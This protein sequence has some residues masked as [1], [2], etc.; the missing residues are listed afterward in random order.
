Y[1]HAIEK[2]RQILERNPNFADALEQIARAYEATGRY[3]EA[4]KL[5]KQVIAKNPAMAEVTALSLG[6]IYLELGNYA[7]ARAHAEL[8][9]KR[10]PGAAHLLLGRIALAQHDYR[11]AEKE[12]RATMSDSHFSMQAAMLASE[13]L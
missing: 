11:T 9:L 5:C 13:S 6:A 1:P 3:A 12:A 4:V 2:L 10:S 8:A 7:D